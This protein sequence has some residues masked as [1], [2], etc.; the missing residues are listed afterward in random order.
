MLQVYPQNVLSSVLG[1][2]VL[3]PEKGHPEMAGHKKQCHRSRTAGRRGAERTQDAGTGSGAGKG[4]G[5][6]FH[7][8]SAFCPLKGCV[9]ACV[10]MW[11]C[12]FVSVFW[13]PVRAC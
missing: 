3:S 1:P 5:H 9:C 7:I 6:Q 8:H 13:P 4:K 2:P 10:C 11:E 12:E